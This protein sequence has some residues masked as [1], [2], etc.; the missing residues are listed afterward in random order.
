[1]LV[2]LELLLL[3]VQAQIKGFERAGLLEVND[4]IDYTDFF[5]HDGKIISSNIKIPED[6]PD[7][8]DALDFI[9]ELQLAHILLWFMIAPFSFIFRVAYDLLR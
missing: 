9:N 2:V 5:P 1:L 7:V 6:Y 8:T 4:S 3:A